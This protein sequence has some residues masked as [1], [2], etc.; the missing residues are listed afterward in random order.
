MVFNPNGDNCLNMKKITLL[1]LLTLSVLGLQAQ[2]YQLNYDSI[3]VGKTAG[4]GG[5]S[6]YGKVYLKNTTTGLSSDSILTVRNGRI[7]KVPKYN[8]GNISH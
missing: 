5:T 6:L 7:F 4:T 1:L 8:R 2:T 3:R